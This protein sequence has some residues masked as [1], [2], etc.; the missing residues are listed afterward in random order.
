MGNGLVKVRRDDDGQL[1]QV[2]FDEDNNQTSLTYP[3]L[4]TW[5]WR[6]KNQKG[7]LLFSDR[8]AWTCDGT[9]TDDQ[10]T[11]SGT[12]SSLSVISYHR[13]GLG[14][15]TKVDDALGMR[16]RLGWENGSL[17]TNE[18]QQTGLFSLYIHRQEDYGG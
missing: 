2:G 18:M 6:R 1:W 11:V 15:L 3:D 9:E 16:L 4:S 7:A 10:G 14:Q 8:S 5:V 12:S 13:D 17:R